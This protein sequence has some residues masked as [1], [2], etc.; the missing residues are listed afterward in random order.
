ML[1]NQILVEWD[2]SKSFEFLRNVI[3][4]SIFFISFFPFLFLII[5]EKVLFCRVKRLSMIWKISL[6]CS[7]GLWH[8]ARPP[9]DD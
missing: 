6:W 7:Y 5:I 3:E 2:F 1:S 9:S 8:A 4:L